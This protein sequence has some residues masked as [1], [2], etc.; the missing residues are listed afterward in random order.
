MSKKDRPI[1]IEEAQRLAEKEG[2]MMIEA[3]GKNRFYLVRKKDFE[4]VILEMKRRILMQQRCFAEQV[5]KTLRTMD[6]GRPL[7]TKYPVK[8]FKIHRPKNDREMGEAFSEALDH[9]RF[10]GPHDLIAVSDVLGRSGK[11]KK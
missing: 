2:F 1:T 10:S 6:I 11:F 9:V 8:G 3:D 4:A 7:V 5:L